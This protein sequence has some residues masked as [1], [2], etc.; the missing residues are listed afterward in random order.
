MMVV[1]MMRWRMEGRLRHQTDSQSTASAQVLTPLNI[2]RRSRNSQ[3]RTTMA[4]QQSTTQVLPPRLQLSHPQRPDLSLS[5][6]I[7]LAVQLFQLLK[8]RL[9]ISALEN[10]LVNFKVRKSSTFLA[11]L[12]S[13]F[14]VQVRGTALSPPALSTTGLPQPSRP[15]TRSPE[16]SCMCV[17]QRV[18]RINHAPSLRLSLLML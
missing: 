13:C 15:D 8:V 5:V 9:F 12:A 18:N 6:S 4:R 11:G 16:R 2:Q 17:E 3:Q 7:F 1:M 14:L 10:C